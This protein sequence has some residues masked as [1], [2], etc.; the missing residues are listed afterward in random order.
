MFPVLSVF[1][2]AVVAAVLVR[3]E[4]RL[5]GVGEDRCKR[6]DAC[7]DHI[8]LVKKLDRLDLPGFFA[9]S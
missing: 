8:L 6:G 9:G 2:A 1:I 3:A 5:V 7:G 4:C